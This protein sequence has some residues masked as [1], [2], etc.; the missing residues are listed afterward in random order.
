MRAATMNVTQPLTEAAAGTHRLDVVKEILTTLETATVAGQQYLMGK[1]LTVLRH[2][3]PPRDHWIN[4]AQWAQIAAELDAL[5]REA[6][7]MSPDAAAF[8]RQ[9]INLAET[10]ARGSAR[11]PISP[12]A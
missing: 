2:Q 6:A 4:E 9:A 12:T 8:S 7:R 1:V 3:A 11:P 10:L 5:A